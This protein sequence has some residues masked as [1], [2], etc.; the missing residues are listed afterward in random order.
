MVCCCIR[1]DLKILVMV[2]TCETLPLHCLNTYIASTLPPSKSAFTRLELVR[3][4]GEWLLIILH[5]VRVQSLDPLC[6]C[7][8][9]TEPTEVQKSPHQ[10]INLLPTR[11]KTHSC[12]DQHI[13]YTVMYS[14]S[15]YT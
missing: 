6:L 5:E 12:I 2:C 15:T 10:T 14:Y 9:H 8:C 11:G 13:T 3:L 4:E 1:R 7:V